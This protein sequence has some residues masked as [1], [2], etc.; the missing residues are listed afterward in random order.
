VVPVCG[1]TLLMLQTGP[2]KDHFAFHGTFDTHYGIFE[3]C[4]SGM[5]FVTETEKGKENAASC[6]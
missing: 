5:P 3:G 6:C 1:N 2:L 4:G